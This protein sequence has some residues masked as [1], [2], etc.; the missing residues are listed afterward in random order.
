MF[1]PFSY[2]AL[3]PVSATVQGGGSIATAISNMFTGAI[4]EREH[5]KRSINTQEGLTKREEIKAVT[6]QE[7]L[8]TKERINEKTENSTTE[9][10][11]ARLKT[12]LKIVKTKADADVKVA[13]TN[14]GAN[15]INNLTSNVVKGYGIYKQAEVEHRALGN[16]E[17]ELELNYK[18]NLTNTLAA[19]A[20]NGLANVTTAIAS[21]SSVRQP[22]TPHYIPI[23]Y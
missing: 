19:H 22:S 1:I 14:A 6:A 8:R 4:S 16:K 2:I 9:R 21:R 18:T 13:F 20:S 10:E 23:A 3:D 17:K 12:E 7:G 11:K 15:V 5:T